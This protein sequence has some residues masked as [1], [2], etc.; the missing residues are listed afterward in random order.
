MEHG[1]R[2]EEIQSATVAEI[3]RKNGRDN[4][5]ALALLHAW[6]DQTAAQ[7]EQGEMT[8]LERNVAWAKLYHDAELT[9][10]AI[11]AFDAA[12]EEAFQTGNR[13]VFNLCEAELKKLRG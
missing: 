10:E 6:L 1:P 8:N 7:V 4:H 12:A 11:E 9:E 5:E 3:L 2:P 13:S